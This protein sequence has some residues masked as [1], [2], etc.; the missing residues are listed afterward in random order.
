MMDP[1][2]EHAFFLAWSPSTK[3]LFGYIWKR[4][5]FPWLGRWEE[6]HL[7]TA[8]PWNGQGLTCGMEFGV[9][10]LLE[11][12]RKMVE[13]GHLFG[14]PAYRWLPARERIE[15]Q[16]CAFTAVSES[17]PEAATWDGGQIVRFE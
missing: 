1:A 17:M 5:D 14:V 7:R 3:L 6:N 12:R 15:V 10:P 2:Q 11:S 8:A 4:E 9:S 13:R 16:Y